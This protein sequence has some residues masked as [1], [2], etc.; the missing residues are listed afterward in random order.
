MPSYYEI[1]GVAETASADEIKRAYRT[2]AMQYHPDRNPGNAEAEAKFKEINEA[3]DVLSDQTKRSQYDQRNSQGPN[4]FSN[5][6]GMHMNFGQGGLDDFISKIFQQ[7]GFG[8][9]HQSPTRNKDINLSMTITL[10]D[11]FQGKQLPIHFNTPS[12]RRVELIVTIPPGVESGIKIR[13]QGQ[14]E[15]AD[16]SFPPG[17]LYIL[18]NVAPHSR[19]HRVGANLETIIQLDA[20]SAI[21]GC[22]KTITCIDGQD[23][24]L[25]IPEGSQP[26]TKLRVSGKG[27]QTKPNATT[28]GDMNVILNLSIPTNLTTEQMSSLR[29]IQTARGVDRL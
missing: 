13:Y 5:M 21:I 18:L 26:N 3:N 17:D 19:F 6:Q 20:I 22:K 24:D 1:L 10:E 15:H 14:G 16:T 25:T 29:E 7:H 28:R 2:L 23:I 9:F 27:M 11:A 12:G 8:T 4:P